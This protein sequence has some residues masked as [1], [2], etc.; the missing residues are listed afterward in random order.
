M[1]AFS[2]A[3]NY[4]C[5]T[6]EE[7]FRLILA[8]SGRGD[9]AEH[10]RLTSAGGR[11]TLSMQDH[12]PFAQAFGDLA[13]LIFID[14]VEEAA[15]YRECLHFADDAGDTFG[16]DEA[17]EENGDAVEETNA[18]S[19]EGPKQEGDSEKPV[20]F[21]IL[22]GAYAAGYMLRTQANGWKLFCERL[23][24]PPFLLWE[25]LPGFDRLQRALALT[26]KA[27]FVSEGYLQ[28]INRVRPKGKPELTVV[29]LTVE[30]VAAANAKAF[31]QRVHWLGGRT[32]S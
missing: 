16:T 10:N 29:P 19:D 24:V 14:L 21:R 31:R 9:E 20:Y 7:R 27:A 17:E 32:D 18:H 23:D 3:K 25:E 12:V 1:K 8:A 15:R 26:E 11:I 2:L 30:G 28:W 4:K 22:E 6:P 13:M 5:L